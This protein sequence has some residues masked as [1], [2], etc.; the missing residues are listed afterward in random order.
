[1]RHQLSVCFASRVV[2]LRCI[3]SHGPRL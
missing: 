3:V 1:L 2:V